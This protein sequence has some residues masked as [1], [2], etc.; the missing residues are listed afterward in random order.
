MLNKLL[1]AFAL[2]LVM[3][4]STLGS[5]AFSPPCTTTKNEPLTVKA[6]DGKILVNYVFGT[7]FLVPDNRL[8]IDKSTY[9]APENDPKPDNREINGV[10]QESRQKRDRE[11]ELE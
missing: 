1:S 2:L 6:T 11:A 10:L 8:E 4:F 3:L 7:V 9:S 5:L